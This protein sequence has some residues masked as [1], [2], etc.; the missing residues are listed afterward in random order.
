VSGGGAPGG[1]ADDVGGAASAQAAARADEIRT[2]WSSYLP[3][4]ASEPETGGAG[5]WAGGTGSADAPPAG[6]VDPEPWRSGPGSG[7]LSA[8][9]P[10]PPL[11]PPGFTAPPASGPS[12]GTGVADATDSRPVF[13]WS[14]SDPTESMPAVSPDEE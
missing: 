11:E 10:E 2:R 3:R 14:S 5:I 8:G 6:G 4:R 12:W 7:V 1:A 13:S 9:L